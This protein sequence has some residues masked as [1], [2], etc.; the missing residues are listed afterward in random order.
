MFEL[1]RRDIDQPLLFMGILGEFPSAFGTRHGRKQWIRPRALEALRVLLVSGEAPAPPQKGE[2]V[3]SSRLV[4]LH[5]YSNIIISNICVDLSLGMDTDGSS[6]LLCSL[7]IA[8]SKQF[9][10]N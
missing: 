9:K 7:S 6:S 8:I 5:F 3:F 1:P 2:A 4:M 10:R